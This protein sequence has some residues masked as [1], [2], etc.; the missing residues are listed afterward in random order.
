MIQT[1]NCHYRCLNR[2]ISRRD[3]EATRQRHPRPFSFE[4][5]ESF[6]GRPLQ[7]PN[8]FAHH[9]IKYEVQ[10][11]KR[12]SL[13]SVV[14]NSELAKWQPHGSHPIKTLSRLEAV[15][16]TVVHPRQRTLMRATAGQTL[17]LVIIKHVVLHSHHLVERQKNEHYLPFK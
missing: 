8:R 12:R 2:L 6:F 9:L 13:I 14:K 15:V 11:L 7:H 10:N 4:P 17:Q 5:A 16:P 1:D 3:L